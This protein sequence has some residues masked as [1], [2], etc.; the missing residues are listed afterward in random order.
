VRRVRRA[1]V[2]PFI[3]TAGLLGATSCIGFHHATPTTTTIV[4]TPPHLI[5]LVTL[6]GTGSS[7]GSGTTIEAIDLSARPVTMR[8]ITV[9][10]FPDAVAI[11]PD[12]KRAYIASYISNTITP[13]DLTTGKEMHPINVG[14]GPAGIAITPNG[15]T[16]YVTDA[17][18]APIG[19]TVTPVDLAKAKALAP[20]TVGAG[21]QGIAITPDGQTAYVADAGAVVT[22]QSGA[23][24]STVTPIDLSTKKA[25]APIKVGNAP[26]AI[27]VSG[28][29]STVYVANANSGSVTPIQAGSATA[30]TPVPVNGAPQAIATTSSRA[31][32]ADTSSTAGGDN[33]SSIDAGAAQVGT[34]V[35]LAKGPTSV[36][37]APGGATAWVVASGAGKLVPV[38]L[39]SGKVLPGSVALTGGPYAVAVAEVPATEA[40]AI[41][42][43]P[44]VKK[45][46]KTSS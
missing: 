31:W 29:G 17:G 22:G 42:T 38:D 19:D 34:T 36:S 14:G 43:T 20:I 44:V 26:I 37:I 24:G 16:A 5:A 41:T 21:P 23:F 6:I 13:I 8:A 10:Q 40:R 18:T 39:G 4:K 9:G 27:A 33:L 11:T 45:K 12:G 7:A 28:D 2:A 35:V 32:V 46:V 3:V 30:G 25:G 1:Q 15:K